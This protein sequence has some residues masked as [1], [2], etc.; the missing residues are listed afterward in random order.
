[1]SSQFFKRLF[2]IGFAFVGLTSL[3]PVLLVIGAIIFV[4]SGVPVLFRQRRVGRWGE[5][6]VLF[7]FRTMRVLPQAENGIFEPG[8]NRRI[9]SVGRWLRRTKLD[10]LP[11]LWNVLRGEMS[12]VGPRP[13]VREWVEPYAERWA[14]IHRVPPGITDPASIRFRNEEA[15]LAGTDDPKRVY[16]EEILP[17][18]LSLYEEYVRNWSFWGDIKIIVTTISAL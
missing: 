17:Q 5:D 9:T 8:S 14:F 18:K 13:E 3:M 10:E 4:T 16:R 15:I 7:K 6:F 2:D 11:Q 1:M 12:V